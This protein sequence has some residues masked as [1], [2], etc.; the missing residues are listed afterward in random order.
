[1]KNRFDRLRDELAFVE[2]LIAKEIK[3]GRPHRIDHLFETRK[4]ILTELEDAWWDEYT[5]RIVS[6]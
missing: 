5:R 1:M 3:R 4:G 2:R 6:R